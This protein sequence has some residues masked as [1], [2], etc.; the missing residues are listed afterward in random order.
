MHTAKFPHRKIPQIHKQLPTIHKPTP[1]ATYKL[2]TRD[3]I[4]QPYQHTEASE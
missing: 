3:N 4:P 2:Y 1:I